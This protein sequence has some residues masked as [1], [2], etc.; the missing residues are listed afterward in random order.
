[1]A[2]AADPQ[3]AVR[4]QRRPRRESAR[5]RRICD[6][7]V[8]GDLCGDRR[9][10]DRCSPS[11]ATAM[12]RA[13]PRRRTRIATARP[14]IVDRNGEVLATDVKA[15]SLFGEPRRIIDKD[16]AIELLTATLPDLDTS[17][18]RDRLSSKKG[19]RLAEARNHAAAA[20]GHSSP[21]RSRH[22]L[23]AREQARLP[24]RRRSRASDR[25]GQYRQPGH[26]RDGEM[27]RQ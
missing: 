8:R 11:A 19:F 25:S 27:A 1:M 3:P 4:A 12:A 24:H 13:A 9:T 16:E 22:R 7:G 5:P 17:E 2:A 21:R 23:P 6:A 20:A 18:V 10:A 15:P 14:D 26:R